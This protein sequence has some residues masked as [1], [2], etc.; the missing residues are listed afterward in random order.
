[1]VFACGA[2]A[3]DLM[4]IIQHRLL[5][6]IFHRF[7]KHYQSFSNIFNDHI[8]VASLYN[9]IGYGLSRIH[10]H[11]LH[12]VLLLLDVLFLLGRMKLGRYPM[13]PV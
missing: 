4:T 11:E 1:M 5:G 3:A 13:R 10:L 12:F 7:T 6:I 2:A 9:I 8:H